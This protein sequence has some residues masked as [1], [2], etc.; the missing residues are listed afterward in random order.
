M[1]LEDIKKKNVYTVPDRYFEELP[2]KI[3]ERVSEKK[4]GFIFSLNW[5]L[6]FQVASP[7]L[8]VLL[9]IFYFG[10][11]T[12]SSSLSAEELLAEVTTEDV[13]AY[14]ETTDLSADEIIE[15]LDLST[16]DLDFTEEGPIME[17]LE[18]NDQDMD[19]LFDEYGIESELL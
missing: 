10:I 15:E 3:Q 2:G 8:A 12:Q 19:L 16:V 13:I 4:P 17:D 5:K 9:L 7:V 1:K 11:G 18:M 14:L 6:A